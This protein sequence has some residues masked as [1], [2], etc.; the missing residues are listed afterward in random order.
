M[1]NVLIEE[2]TMTDIANAIRAK[3][4]TVEKMKPAEMPQVIDNIPCENI[5]PYLLC[6]GINYK[7]LTINTE[8]LKV[9]LPYLQNNLSQFL[10]TTNGMQTVEIDCNGNKIENLSNINRHESRI[11]PTIQKIIIKNADLS[12]CTSYK[13]AFFNGWGN[14]SLKEIDADLDFSSIKTADSVDGALASLRELEK[15]RFVPN[16]LSVNLI[17]KGSPLLTA[18]SIQSIIDGLA[19]LTGQTAQTITLH[20]TVKNKLTEEQ[21]ASATSKNWNIA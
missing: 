17:F 8:I 19:D 18:E 9:R 21:I 11:K 7:N 6:T 12:E 1:A 13:Y 4:G 5:E 14:S 10:F 16:T 2:K 3:S 15:I 20:P